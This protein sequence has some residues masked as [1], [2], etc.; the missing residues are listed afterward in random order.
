MLCKMPACFFRRKVAVFMSKKFEAYTKQ[1]AA[2]QTDKVTVAVYGNLERADAN[3]FAEVLDSANSK[4]RVT[5]N[6]FQNGKG[7]DAV[8]VYYN[9]SVA[10]LNYIFDR[11]K[12]NSMPLFKGIKSLDSYPEK[13]GQYAGLAQ[14]RTIVI[15]FMGADYTYPWKIEIVNGYGKE[16]KISTGM[17]TAKAF[18]NEISFY[19]LLSDTKRYIDEYVRIF[20]PD[21]IKNGLKKM[22]EYKRGYD[23]SILQGQNYYSD[24]VYQFDPDYNRQNSGTNTAE[25]QNTQ[26]K[27]QWDIHPT[28][29]QFV[30]DFIAM[31]NG[32]AVQIMCKGMT[33]TVYCREVT[34]AMQ[35]ARM[36]GIAVTANLF[37][38]NGQYFMDG[39]AA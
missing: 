19:Q 20:A 28:K 39:I 29:V 38:Y 22:E 8:K 31:E 3:R 35:K 37:K 18:L 1:C 7:D 30:S 17:K 9:L 34:E 15:Q 27:S 14:I 13:E 16:G 21:M 36:E 32:F 25:K 12:N 33:Y 23:E 10:E 2:Y 5:I 24:N 26:S 11:F 6:D 4:I